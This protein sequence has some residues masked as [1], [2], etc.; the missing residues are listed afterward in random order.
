MEARR[1][2]IKSLDECVWQQC[3]QIVVRVAGV[4]KTVSKDFS[5]PGPKPYAVDMQ[6]VV[7]RTLVN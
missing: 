1:N 7:I 6:V 5:V 2:V 4:G 3:R